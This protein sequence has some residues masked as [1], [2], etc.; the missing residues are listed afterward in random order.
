MTFDLVMTKRR[1]RTSVDDPFLISAAPPPTIT[2][3][4]HLECK[5][6]Y[7]VVFGPNLTFTLC[8]NEYKYLGKS[9]FTWDFA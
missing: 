2:F 7:C 6:V 3:F 8:S 1:D 9:T 5:V 4:G